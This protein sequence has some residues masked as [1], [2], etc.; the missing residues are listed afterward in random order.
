MSRYLTVIRIIYF[1]VFCVGKLCFE[2]LLLL[3]EVFVS[4]GT[5]LVVSVDLYRPIIVIY[6]T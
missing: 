3:K 1:M 2:I 4:D 6:N 5:A